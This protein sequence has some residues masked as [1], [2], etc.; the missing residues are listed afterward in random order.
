MKKKITIVLLLAVFATLLVS[1]KKVLLFKWNDGIVQVRNLYKYTGG[2][3]DVLVLGSSHVFNDVNTQTLFDEYG[4]AAYVLA[5]SG[6]PFWNSYVYL[7]E[8]LKTQKPKLVVLEGLS[9]SLEYLHADH[10]GIVKNNFGL[11]NGLLKFKSVL[12]S[13]PKNKRDDYL[14]GYRLYHSRYK[15]LTAQDSKAFYQK[16]RF[17]DNKGF[18]TAPKT[19][20]QTRPELSVT[21]TTETLPLNKKH[22]KYF[23]KI[24]ETC[25]KENIPVLVFVSPYV[26]NENIQKH[27]NSLERLA[28]DLS[29]KFINYN[30]SGK[31]DEIG[32]DF[33]KDFMDFAH[34]NHSGSVKLSKSLGAY[35]KNNFSVPDRRGDKEYVSWGISSK[36][37]KN[38]SVNENIRKADNTDDFIKNIKENKGIKLY[39][40]TI[41]STREI[42]G[43][44][45]F[46][47]LGANG[48]ALK[49]GR[50]YGFDNGALTELSGNKINWRH[51]A[52]LFDEKIIFE[53]KRAYSDKLSAVNSLFY[54]G[55]EYI[56]DKNGTYIVAYDT[57]SREVVAVRQIVCKK[58]GKECVLEL[59]KK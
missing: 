55:K 41:S 12:V 8:A 20:K 9:S 49:D 40:N 6:Q 19:E 52:G 58:D 34:L 38:E 46:K 24:M 42:V 32:L 47:K 10:G 2:G 31:Y 30:R 26:I 13:A 36:I 45:F 14:F 43:K 53:Q 21:E 57:V 7:K 17:R 22:Q 39:I 23:L 4:I 16:G 5:G 56:D 50:L 28:K 37:L 25:K 54:N 11:K 35:I 51:V 44:G 33:S 48:T 1:V 15:E 3:I 29:V 59:V 27:F 18:F